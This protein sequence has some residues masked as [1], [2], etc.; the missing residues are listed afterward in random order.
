MK[1]VAFAHPSA[2]TLA[3]CADPI[4]G[5]GQ[6]VVETAVSA[7]C[8]SELHSYRQGGDRGNPGHEAA[9]IVVEV[10]AGVRHLNPGDRVG[11]SAVAGCGTCAECAAGRYTWCDRRDVFVNMHAERFVIP[12][13]ACHRL[14]D[15]VAWDVGVLIAG[16]GLGVPF[17]TYEKT[18]KYA[19]KTLAVIGL[20]P[21]GL[22]NVLVQTHAG[23][24]V[25]GIDLSPERLTL[26]RNLG[27]SAAIPA[28]E[29]LH[30]R[31][32]EVTGGTG[33]DAVIEAV[34]RPATVRQAIDLTPRGGVV[35]LNGECGEDCIQP[36]RDLIRRDITVVGS[37]FYHFGE[38]PAMLA[39]HR[40]G[41]RVGDL[42]T[43]RFPL[44][45]A[46]AAYTAFAG[47]K[48]GKVLLTKGGN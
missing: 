5:P 10:G 46:P 6:V 29:G 26:A 35:F 44:H 22:G 40:N 15:D 20:G 28:G 21:I 18:R 8:G 48:T 27:A 43:H 4:A 34:G 12:A 14:P 16:D 47:G 31:L 7:L 42:V 36:S 39:M 25:I 32:M 2:V 11:V 23:R 33:V 37:W 38:F 19:I 17:H 24:R 45:D 9:G 41:L 13:L 1:T 30:E 3:D